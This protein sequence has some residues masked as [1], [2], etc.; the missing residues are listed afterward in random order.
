[1]TGFSSWFLCV[2]SSSLEVR[3]CPAEHLSKTRI[4]CT[5]HLSSAPSSCSEAP[6][7]LFHGLLFCAISI[8][9]F[10]LSS[11]VSYRTVPTLCYLEIFDMLF[12]WL[13]GSVRPTWG[14]KSFI[15]ACSINPRNNSCSSMV[16]FPAN[17]PLGFSIIQYFLYTSTVVVNNFKCQCFY[18]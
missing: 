18:F 10:L 7:T 15:L 5:E 3:F 4:P 16:A 8:G 12:L 2:C 1:M 17:I 6:V 13:E 14:W 9:N 11:V